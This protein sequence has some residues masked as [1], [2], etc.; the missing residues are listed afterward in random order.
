[1]NRF[2]LVIVLIVINVIRVLSQNTCAT[3]IPIN[4]ASLPYASGALTTCGTV[5]NYG[6]G[7]G[8]CNATY[9]GGE[10]YV[11]ALNITSA[12]VTLA[13]TMG[14][15]GL[16][17]I[18]QV[19][20]G[21]PSPPASP[22]NCLGNFTGN[23]NGS[24]NFTFPSTGTYYIVI[25]TW[26]APPCGAFTLGISPPPT[27]PGGLGTINNVASFP[28]THT[29]NTCGQGNEITS[30]NATPICGSSSYYNEE[31]AV[32]T[33]TPTSTGVVTIDLATA[34]SWSAL[35]LYNGCPFSG[36]AT[37]VASSQSSTGP[38]TMCV[39]LT[40]GVPYTLI[41]DSWVGTGCLG[42]YTL[43]ISSC[44]S[45]PPGGTA[46]S[47]SPT[48]CAAG[49]TLAL[50]VT[51]SSTGTCSNTYQ[52][53]SAPVAAGPWTTIGGATAVT[54]T[55]SVSGSICYR[56][57]TTCAAGTGT[58]T[59]VCVSLA[60]CVAPTGGNAVATPTVACAPGGTVALST[61]GGS[62]G[63][64]FTYQWQSAP[65]AGGPWTN[66]AGATFSTAAG[67]VNAP[68]TC[69]RRIISCGA[70][71]A[72]SAAV[73]VSPS[74]NCSSQLG[75]GV[76]AVAS[77][78]YSTSGTTCGSG[79]DLT[80]ANV[81]TGGCSSTSYL[82]GEDQVFVFTPTSS[83]MITIN[84]TSTG[85]WTGLM[86]YNTCPLTCAGSSGCVGSSTSSTGNKS[87]IACVVA[88]TTYYLIL[89]SFAAPACNPYS[90]LTIS[91]PSVSATTN[92]FC[93]S[94]I[95]ITSG[96]SYSTNTN[97]MTADSPGNLAS[98]F[99]GSIE[100]NQW[101]S[102]VASAS[103][104]TFGFSGISGTNCP[105]GVQ[106]QVFTTS[107]TSTP[108]P[109]CT[110]FTSMSTP[111]YNP[112]SLASGTLTASGLT[113]GQT[114]Y[115]MVD[116]NGGSQC[117]FTIGGWNIGALPVDLI[118]F[119]GKNYSKSLNKLD[120]NVAM[121]RN[122]DHYLIQRSFDAVK[123]TDLDKV[124]PGT[125]GAAQKSYS[126][127]DRN[128]TESINYYRLK[129]VDKDQTFKYSSLIAIN[130]FEDSKFKINKIFP[131]PANSEI[132]ASVDAP[133]DALLE[134]EILDFMGRV[135]YKDKQHLKFGTNMININLAS[136]K[137][138]IYYFKFDCNKETKVEKFS[139]Q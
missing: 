20:T 139:L 74:S 117:N 21:C 30:G 44:T 98:V 120:W 34:S 7:S 75:T 58:S 133:T 46:V 86:L 65:A 101:F 97:T 118:S 54:Y 11:F 73:C 68:T 14:G 61:T 84:L 123:F 12:P 57:L 105:A 81:A 125:S 8:A 33:F 31:D 78:P 16:W 6:V 27:C 13:F 137:K 5:D 19:F 3:A 80:T 59:S 41:L 129:I 43:N 17:K 130:T 79:N 113:V 114:Y 121:E 122:L 18:C 131:N 10:D 103:T 24:G 77:L 85:T 48:V 115:L 2:L 110:N 100:N 102:F 70:S 82:S 1:M 38:K 128:F 124:Y 60:T 119:E 111:C 55:P 127:H 135:V 36:T 69:F 53:Q 40:A 39:N 71:S 94:P 64:G 51:G 138:G 28:Y 67:T 95:P 92:D 87:L 4:Q 63:C 50:S 126:Y 62:S 106:G 76:I 104:A 96:G 15:A 9:G 23:P 108:C 83:G 26:P 116:G 88:G 109:S 49:G 112:A 32:Y 47:S 29:S 91:A 99:C 132:F 93:Q 66:I 42:A 107:M 52:W 35:M 25:D 134:F 90:S 37:C 136:F 22:S 72:T 45:A 89:D 56:R